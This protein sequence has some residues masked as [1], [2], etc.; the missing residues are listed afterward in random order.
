MDISGLIRVYFH[1]VTSITVLVCVWM[2]YCICT[3]NSPCMFTSEHT[4]VMRW[5]MII[6]TKD[7][8]PMLMH[9]KSR[10]DTKSF[11]TLGI[12]KQGL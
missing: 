1:V 4:L 6:F 12:K 9:S 3:M 8:L 11:Q 7:K 2:L 5:P 10:N